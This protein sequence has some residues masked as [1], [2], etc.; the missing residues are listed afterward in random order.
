V[1][2]NSLIVFS[3]DHGEGMGEHNYYF[4]HGDH[5]YSELIH[6][7]LILR[8]GSELKGKQSDTAKFRC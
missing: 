3:S 2:D 8:Y 4:A 6:V 1:Y 5:L 7:P